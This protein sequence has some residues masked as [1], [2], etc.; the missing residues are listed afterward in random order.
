MKKVQVQ[1]QV[2][3]PT[4]HVRIVHVRSDT[5]AQQQERLRRKIRST[6]HLG[7]F[8]CSQELKPNHGLR[9]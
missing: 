4:Q 3:T 5:F 7:S 2:F 1:V 9:R 6:T 8:V